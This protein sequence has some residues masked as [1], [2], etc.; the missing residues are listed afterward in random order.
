[1]T[2]SKSENFL[3]RTLNSEMTR[4]KFMKVSGKSIVGVAISAS[5][6]SLIGCTQEQVTSGKVRVWSTPQGLLVVNEA[7]CTGCQRCEI[8]CTQVNDGY[9]SSYV[10]R[11]KVS[12]NLMLSHLGN[13]LLTDNWVYF[14]D[15]C[16]QCEDPS[17]GNACPVQAISSDD[18]G[19]KKVD[20]SKCVGC[21]TCTAQ[22]PWEMP[23]VNPETRKSS[24]CI[25]CGSCATGCPTGALSVV[26]W[27]S[28]TAALQK[29]R[30]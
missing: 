13:G 23:T 1:M 10:S 6:L 18:R 30:K 19:V 24:K 5:F 4:R 22:C 3:D 8:N 2:V 7:K 21:G 14:P 29:T 9:V 26:D 12:R 17:C 11:A 25:L 27:D 16:R 28:V 20:Q 15:T